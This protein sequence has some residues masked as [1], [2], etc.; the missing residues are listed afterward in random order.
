MAFVPSY[1]NDIFISYAHRDN[2]PVYAVRWVEQFHN[3]LEN[4]LT[5]LLGKGPTIWRDRR[6]DTADLVDGQLDSR[7]N[8]SALLLAIVSPS[9]FESKWCAW[10]REKFI[11]GARRRGGLNVANKSRVVKVVKT[12]VEFDRFPAEFKETLGRAFLR[13][14]TASGR[15][16]EFEPDSTEYK[17]ELEE[18]AQSLATLLDLMR[19]HAVTAPIA[20]GETIY[21]A[22]TTTTDERTALHRAFEHKYNILPYEPLSRDAQAAALEAHVRAS[23][24]KAKLSVHLLGSGYGFVPEDPDEQD[25][26][27]VRLQHDAAQAH[28][29][30]DPTFKQ[31]IWIPKGLEDDAKTHGKQKQFIR[32]LLADSEA[33]R[34]ADILRVDLE[35]LKSRID[36]LMKPPPP[37]V[38]ALKGNG[39]LASVYL[40]CDSS[41]RDDAQPIEDFLN[42]NQCEVLPPLPESEAQFV[43]YHQENLRECD[44]FLVY[45]NHPNEGW[46]LMK[47]QEFMKLPGLRQLAGAKPVLAKAFFITGDKTPPKERFRSNEA[48]VVKHFD[49]FA[50]H[51]L[52]PFL[53]Q[54]RQAKGAAR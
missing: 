38:V 32:D 2:L 24:Q 21:L 4:R 50:P 43:Q 39:S 35:A 14:D 46:A 28:A 36:E 19:Q 52:Q 23:M 26:S 49:Q 22:E 44:A 54:I 16:Y 12:F 31:L 5:Q 8:T 27:I 51:L 41:D 13:E 33:Q 18:L 1:E 37:P 25:R 34:R 30:S 11:E 45:Y 42:D 9:Y 15:R 7:I 53:D 47:K 3:N 10:E 48:L 6:L 40:I 20:T 17:R 29:A